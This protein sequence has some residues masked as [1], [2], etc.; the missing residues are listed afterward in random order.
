MGIDIRSTDT[1]LEL[2][3][4]R[5]VFIRRS[6][7]VPI[8]KGTTTTTREFFSGPSL[9]LTDAHRSESAARQRGSVCG[10]HDYEQWSDHLFNPSLRQ[11]TVLRSEY[12]KARTRV[13]L[14]MGEKIYRARL[15]APNSPRH[16]NEFTAYRAQDSTS[17]VT[18]VL[19]N[20]QI[21]VFPRTA[22]VSLAC[23]MSRMTI[24]RVRR[25]LS[26]TEIE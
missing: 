11:K 19:Y 17:M 6:H 14:R 18:I 10:P 20:P 21:P 1:N 24:M 13:C 12:W 22:R 2:V 8:R 23:R 7:A 26:E 4:A 9:E 5:Y 15:L 3:R 16:S 25:T